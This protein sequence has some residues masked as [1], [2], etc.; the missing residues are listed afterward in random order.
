MKSITKILAGLAL[1]GSMAACTDG[2]DWDV[3]GSETGLFRPTSPKAEQTAKGETTINFTFSGVPGA[4]GYQIEATTDSATFVASDEV[5]SDNILIEATKSPVEQDGFVIGNTYYSRIRAI[6]ANGKSSWVGISK[7]KMEE[8]NLFTDAEITSTRINFLWTPTTTVSTIVLLNAD[9]EE[10]ERV[11]LDEEAITSGAYAF[12]GLTPLTTYTAELYAGVNRCGS[13]SVETTSSAAPGADKTITYNASK[14]MQEQL[15]AVAAEAEAGTTYTVT[16]IIP[17]D[18]ANAKADNIDSETGNDSDLKIPAG[19]SVTF[20]GEF[21]NAKNTLTIVKTINIA[22]SHGS[23]TF[24]NLTITGNEYLINQSDLCN[25]ESIIVKDCKVSDFAKSLIR[26]QGGTP[27]G[28]IGT[29]KLENSIFSNI[30]TG[31]G[32]IHMDGAVID[33]INIDGCTFNGICTAGKCFFMMTRYI[34]A[35]QSF[36]IANSTFYN[37]CGNGKFFL[38]FNDAANGPATFE[39]KNV[40]FGKGADDVTDKNVR[41]TCNTA[42]GV[43]NCK[44]A[45]DFYKVIKGVEATGKTSAEIFTDPEN[46]DFTLKADCGVE[47]CGDPRWYTTAE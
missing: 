1:V 7:V 39:M 23:I 30:G 25:V 15:D 10:L 32:F 26:T 5:S 45:S 37:F 8:V 4:T 20:Y 41:G 21:A 38:D 29:I 34:Y 47:K 46:G 31:Y 13:K 9:G 35:T 16:V 6:S 36:T 40:L 42:D 43:E 44:S 24:E 14:T 17:A 19:M 33:N 18:A 12:T 27:D 22:G 2:N 11:E 3:D 28:K